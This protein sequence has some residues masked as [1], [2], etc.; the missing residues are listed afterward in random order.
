MSRRKGDES[1]CN[2]RMLTFLKLELSQDIG[3]GEGRGGRDSIIVWDRSERASG[4]AWSA[5]PIT[6]S[7]PPSRRREAVIPLHP[8]LRL[9][10]FSIVAQRGCQRNDSLADGWSRPGCWWLNLLVVEQNTQ[11]SVTLQTTTRC[12]CNCP[13]PPGKLGRGALSQRARHAM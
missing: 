8:P 4:S 9:V 10:G 3:G 6:V 5:S 1:S 12:A 7:E 2:M 13:C 11:S